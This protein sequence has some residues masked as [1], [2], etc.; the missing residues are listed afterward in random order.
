MDGHGV[1]RV[2]GI[3]HNGD[4]GGGDDGAFL[5]GQLAHAL[6]R[7][8]GGEDA[9]VG[10]QQVRHGL[11]VEDHGIHAG[12][13]LPAAHLR[14]S[15][16]DGLGGEGLSVDG[17]QLSQLHGK[18]VGHFGSVGHH[19]HA[20]HA[21]ALVYITQIQALGIVDGDAVT[22]ADALGGAAVDDLLIGGV[23]GFLGLQHGAEQGLRGG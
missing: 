16:A 15:A 8:F 23:K 17:V 20:D 12:G 3:V 18:M 10:F 19:S 14:Q 22:F 9:A 7:R 5:T 1:F 13:H 21:G 6:L 2:E 4:D 11:G